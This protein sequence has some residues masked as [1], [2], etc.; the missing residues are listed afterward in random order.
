MFIFLPTATGARLVTPHLG[1][2]APNLYLR[3]GRT[4]IGLTASAKLTHPRV[5]LNCLNSPP[6]NSPCG[7][8]LYFNPHQEGGDVAP[9][10]VNH[11]VKDIESL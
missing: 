2:G 5:G 4:K 7:G 8:C 6:L 10:L 11:C 1:G 3:P 9:D